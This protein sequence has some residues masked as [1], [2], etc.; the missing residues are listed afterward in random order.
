MSKE[1]LIWEHPTGTWNHQTWDGPLGMDHALITNWHG[2]TDCLYWNR[3]SGSWYCNVVP[4][5]EGGGFYDIT[6]EEAFFHRPI[7]EVP[8]E[9]RAL[10]LLLG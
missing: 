7:H 10:A 2:P 6:T 5:K 8:S 4:E 9:V 3:S 1:I